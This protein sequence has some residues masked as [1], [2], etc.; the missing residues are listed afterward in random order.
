M[1]TRIK[2]FILS[3]LEKILFQPWR[4]AKNKKL[5][6]RFIEIF[7]T[8]EFNSEKINCSRKHLEYFICACKYYKF[9]QI[10]MFRFRRFSILNV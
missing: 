6:A 4:S 10:K 7:Q 2:R 5:F 9:I 1:K 8:D 3:E